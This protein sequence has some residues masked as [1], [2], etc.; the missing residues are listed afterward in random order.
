M[1]GN[2]YF[3]ELP[4]CAPANSLVRSSAGLLSAGQI[5]EAF[6]VMRSNLACQYSCLFPLQGSAGDK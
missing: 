1:A 6:K 2:G 5:S 3:L 4:I